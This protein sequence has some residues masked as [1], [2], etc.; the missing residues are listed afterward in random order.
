MDRHTEY[1]GGVAHRSCHQVECGCTAPPAMADSYT[2][3]TCFACGLPVCVNPGDETDPG[4][5]RVM[6]WSHYGRRRVCR[7]CEVDNERTSARWEWRRAAAGL[8][9]HY[10][11]VTG[12][13]LCGGG[14][15]VTGAI[16]LK[17]P[18]A[19]RCGSCGR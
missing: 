3:G 10:C 18:F 7:G 6:V 13:K 19:D 16:T 17:P 11:S 15:I 12:L 14:F 9:W 2:R 1:G 4:C 8:K 5:S